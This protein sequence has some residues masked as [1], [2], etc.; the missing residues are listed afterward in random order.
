MWGFWEGA[1]W[2]PKAALWKRNWDMTPAA[3]AYR[4]SMLAHA[5]ALPIVLERGPSTPA[6]MRPVEVLL[7]I[8]REAGLSP[9]RATAGMNAIA[10]L[11][12]G[13][14]AMVGGRDEGPPSPEALEAFRAQFSAQEFPYFM[15]AAQYGP[16]Y[17]GEDFEFGVRALARGLLASVDE[18]DG[19]A[20]VFRERHDPGR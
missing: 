6:A 15:E 4:D 7:G 14:V 17:L 3:R 9:A 8:L 13:L 19:H 10:A 2:R 11:V 16:D 5:N 20:P 18:P 12:R 1:H